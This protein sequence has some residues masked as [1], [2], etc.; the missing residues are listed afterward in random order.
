MTLTDLAGA[1]RLETGDSFIVPFW[2]WSSIS[3]AGADTEGR[4]VLNETGHS[5]GSSE[6]DCSDFITVP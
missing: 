5:S 2:N 3:V 1:D 4:A 6:V